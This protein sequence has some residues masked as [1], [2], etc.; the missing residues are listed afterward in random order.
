MQWMIILSVFSLVA[1]SNNSSQDNEDQSVEYVQRPVWVGPG[2]YYGIWFNNEEDYN[3]WHDDHYNNGNHQQDGNR[4][5][6]GGNRGQGGGS[7]R[8]NQDRGGG[9]Q[10]GGGGR[11]GG[12]GHG[13]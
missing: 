13:R 8:N 1:S 4:Q 9:G 5:R 12:G 6:D 10:R 11:G 2:L 3:T 7:Q